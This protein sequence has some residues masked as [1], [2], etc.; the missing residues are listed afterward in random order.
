MF[1]PFFGLSRCVLW[2]LDPAMEAIKADLVAVNAG[3]DG[4]VLA[5]GR[6]SAVETINADAIVYQQISQLHRAKGFD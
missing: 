1:T 2:A 3:V 6:A 5:E 4:V